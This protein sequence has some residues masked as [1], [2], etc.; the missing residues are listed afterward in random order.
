MKN[1]LSYKHFNHYSAPKLCADSTVALN[2]D[3][4]PIYTDQVLI[5]DA[6]GNAKFSA[7]TRKQCF[8][9]ARTLAGPGMNLYTLNWLYD[10][11][12]TQQAGYLCLL[13]PIEP[14]GKMLG[15][16]SA[17]D[18]RRQERDPNNYNCSL[19]DT[20]EHGGDS[21]LHCKYDPADPSA[22]LVKS[23]EDRELLDALF[24]ALGKQ[25]Q[26]DLTAIS[27]IYFRD[28]TFRDAMH[29]LGYKS[30]NS[31][32]QRVDKV[33]RYLAEELKSFQE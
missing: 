29:E 13:A 28:M 5:H 18:L 17:S 23:A 32:K 3:G 11:D 14:S 25:K 15:N 26:I 27:A 9:T 10:I 22:D 6:K 24:V 16:F 8:D 7:M 31:V 30:P 2:S 21:N 12:L 20:A 1:Y 19:D 33:L 4:L